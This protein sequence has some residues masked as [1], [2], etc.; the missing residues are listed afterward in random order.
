MPSFN[1]IYGTQKEI[2]Q[3]IK[4]MA[5]VKIQDPK[6]YDLVLLALEKVKEVSDS[7]INERKVIPHVKNNR[8]SYKLLSGK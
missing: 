8:D 5:Q 3:A 7:R 2:D 1:L 4:M 6:K